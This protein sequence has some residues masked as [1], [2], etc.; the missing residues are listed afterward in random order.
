MSNPP[1]TFTAP[2]PAARRTSVQSLPTSSSSSAPQPSLALSPAAT[3][4]PPAAFYSYPPSL[5]PPLPFFSNPSL[6]LPRSPHSYNAAANQLMATQ[7]LPSGL[8]ASS[9]ALGGNTNMLQPS[10][11]Q[12]LLY[13]A[14]SMQ[15]QQQQQ[16]A[17][18][19]QQSHSTMCMPPSVSSLTTMSSLSSDAYHPSSGTTTASLL[20][21][22][23][24]FVTQSLS[25]AG[26]PLNLSSSAAAAALSLMSNAATGGV[27]QL[28]P[29]QFNI[30]AQ[31]SPTFNTTP[32]SVPI[33]VTPPQQHQQQQQ[34]FQQPMQQQQQQQTQPHSSHTQQQQQHPSIINVLY[35]S[36]M[37]S[38]AAAPAATAMTN[39]HSLTSLSTA[40]HTTLPTT[41]TTAT[42]AHF[43][44]PTPTTRLTSLGSYGSLHSL[45]SELSVV[46]P[47][48]STE[49]MLSLPNPAMDVTPSPSASDRTVSQ[50]SFQRLS[51]STSPPQQLSRLVQHTLSAS[52]SSSNL[53]TSS[54]SHVLL[55][56]HNPSPAVPVAGN[57]ASHML[58]PGA[59]SAAYVDSSQRLLMDHD[60]IN[61]YLHA[62]VAS[63]QA[64]TSAVVHERAELL[65]RLSLDKLKQASVSHTTAAGLQ[66]SAYQTSMAGQSPLISPHLQ[67]VLT[68]YALTLPHTN[69]GFFS[70]LAAISSPAGVGGAVPSIL[71]PQQPLGARSFSAPS[72]ILSPTT[73]PA[74][75]FTPSALSTASASPS[76]SPSSSTS[77][78]P[79]LLER[80][81]GRSA[82]TSC[83]YCG[84]TWLL[85]SLSTPTSREKRNKQLKAKRDH[86]P[87]C[88]ANPARVVNLDKRRKK[89]KRREERERRN[90]SRLDGT[91]STG[92]VGV[93]GG[94]EGEAEA[95]VDGDEEQDDEDSVSGSSEM[96]DEFN[97]TTADDTEQSEAAAGGKRKRRSSTGADTEGSTAQPAVKAETP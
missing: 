89:K 35:S 73:H 76:S 40:T 78:S 68:Q 84:R 4:S 75:F 44:Q 15:Q 53:S 23:P 79:S 54:S 92:E 2:L 32:M 33:Y 17:A 22:Q 6:P 96:D 24:A 61:A 16:A 41:S 18:A 27:G 3:V 26:L 80:T 37:P 66:Q 8:S 70:E 11:H 91:G 86:Q 87:F 19:Q 7:Q 45:Q 46:S 10:Q 74:A 59:L 51:P 50:L 65:K 58:P 57:M 13:L 49:S 81:T 36:S 31:S 69:A 55:P 29:Q 94:E 30:R 5:S 52:S 72:P 63:H 90:K 12:Q 47:A 88:V 28:P 56:T 48:P 67:A 83:K 64:G 25:H 43:L 95:E 93:G 14:H 21:A 60:Y 20:S 38:A 85:S 1:P 62:L 34:H 9:F 82:A 42:A 39:L 97:D 77:S 71:L